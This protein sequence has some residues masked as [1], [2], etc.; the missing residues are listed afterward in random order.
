MAKALLLAWASPASQ[1]SDAEFEQWYEHTHIPQ[2]RAAIPSIGPVSRYALVD[3]EAGGQ[4]RFL[5]VYEMDDD[6]IPSAAAALGDGVGSGRIQMSES[7]DLVN[8]PPQLQWYRRH[9]ADPAHV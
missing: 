5:A 4:T 6:D 8:A 2:V 1:E 3:P 9:P 7:L